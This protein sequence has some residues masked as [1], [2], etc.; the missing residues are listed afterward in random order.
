MSSGVVGRVRW[1]DKLWGSSP[2][3][4][5]DKFLSNMERLDQDFVR[6]QGERNEAI[7]QLKHSEDR[8]RALSEAGFES[9]VIHRE[10][11][12]VAV[13]DSFEELTGFLEHELLTEPSLIWDIMDKEH[14]LT[15]KHSIESRDMSP[16]MSVLCCKSGEKKVVW[17]RPKYVNFNGH[18]KCRAAI[19]TLWEDR[20]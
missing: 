19:I 2:V 20:T 4:I 13:N 12:V 10:G 5:V 11:L 6:I 16:Y 9:I 18:G 15:T 3:D 7:K 8:F 17:I 14:N 1:W